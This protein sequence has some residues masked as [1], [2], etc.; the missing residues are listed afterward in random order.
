MS[1]RRRVSYGGVAERAIALFGYG[2]QLQRENKEHTSL[3]KK[4][5]RELSRE[6][7]LRPWHPSIYEVTASFDDAEDP[8]QR[9]TRPPRLL[10]ARHQPA[11]R[12]G[13]HAPPVRRS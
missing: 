3:F 12:I 13:R 8:R 4:V 6:L 10:P 7:G 2:L 9:A 1:K 5:D 11:P